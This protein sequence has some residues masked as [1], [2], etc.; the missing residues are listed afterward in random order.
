MRLLLGVVARVVVGVVGLRAPRTCL[1]VVQSSG[2][3][4]PTAS[5]R[6]YQTATAPKSGLLCSP[7]ACTPCSGV[8]ATVA[9]SYRKSVYVPVCNVKPRVSIL[10]W[11]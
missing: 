11:L 8:A 10:L 3:V 5:L 1:I 7:A 9:T 2:H 4:P 6:M